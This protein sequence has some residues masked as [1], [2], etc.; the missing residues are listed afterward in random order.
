[1]HESCGLQDDSDIICTKLVCSFR[2]GKK[3]KKKRKI[4]GVPTEPLCLI[5]EKSFLST[6]TVEYKNETKSPYKFKRIF[7]LII[8]LPFY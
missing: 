6:N 1:M 5:L 4:S 8:I 3:V 2:K 7:V